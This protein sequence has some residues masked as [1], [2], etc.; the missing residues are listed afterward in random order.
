MRD[1]LPSQNLWSLGRSPSA[2]DIALF[3]R[4]VVW[5]FDGADDSFFG[6]ISEEEKTEANAC[7]SRAGGNPLLIGAQLTRF[8][9]TGG[10][11]NSVS[12]MG[13]KKAESTSV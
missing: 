10:R 11:F 6:R 4:S 9:A 8:S 3:H 7:L 1:P 2:L 13:M 5:I 12:R